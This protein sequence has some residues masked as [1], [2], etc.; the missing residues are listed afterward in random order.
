MSR[1][2]PVFTETLLTP[3][4][5]MQD[6]ACAQTDPDMFFPT[7]GDH[8]SEARAVCAVCPVR[9]ECLAYALRTGQRIGIWGGMSAAERS[10]IG[11]EP[12]RACVD[13]GADIGDRTTRARRC[14]RCSNRRR[15]KAA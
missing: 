15:G 4:P 7:P 5:W 12:T 2:M 1:P 6:A 3:E 11:A 8:A 13:C 10:R 9:D 14:V